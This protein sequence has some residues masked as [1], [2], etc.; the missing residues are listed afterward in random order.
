MASTD[1]KKAV[2]AENVKK[3]F[4]DISAEIIDRTNR[5]VLCTG[6]ESEATFMCPT[7]DYSQIYIEVSFIY[8]FKTQTLTV[9]V[10]NAKYQINLNGTQQIEVITYNNSD[11]VQVR[12]TNN[13][14]GY[15]VLRVVG[16]R[17]GGGNS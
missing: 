14:S 16:I 13:P 10:Q 8:G 4:S 5:E 12:F 1:D 9:P 11:I 6:T 15:S 17:N 2:S 3:M 7:S